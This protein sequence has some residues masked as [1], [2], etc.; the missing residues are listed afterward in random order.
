[1]PK[2]PEQFDFSKAEDQQ[3]LEKLPKKEREKFIESQA[4]E[5]Y[6]INDLVSSG[7][8]GNFERADEILSEYKKSPDFSFEELSGSLEKVKD[9]KEKIQTE[10]QKIKE[11]QENLKRLE[12]SKDNLESNRELLIRIAKQQG[13]ETEE[14]EKFDNKR[15][16]KRVAGNIAIEKAEEFIGGEQY[17]K[18]KE[19]RASLKRENLLVENGIEALRKQKDRGPK[20]EKEWGN[21]QKKQEQI[22]ERRD[23]ISSELKTLINKK[24]IGDDNLRLVAAEALGLTYDRESILYESPHGVREFKDS[25]KAMG[26]DMFT[27]DGR[28]S[29]GDTYIGYKDRVWEKAR[30]HVIKEYGSIQGDEKTTQETLT[31]LQEQEKLLK[32]KLTGTEENKKDL[33]VKFNG[34][35]KL[36]KRGNPIKNIEDLMP[37]VIKFVG[38]ENPAFVKVKPRDG[39]VVMLNNESHYYGSGG[40]ESGVTASIIRNEPSNKD[41]KYYIWRDPYDQRKDDRR[42]Y[43][44]RVKILKVEKDSVK[45]KLINSSKNF[46]MALTLNVKEI[47]KP[48]VKEVLAEEEQKI[49]KR[50]YDKIR[51]KLVEDSFLSNAIMPDYINYESFEGALPS[52]T[53]TE[54][55]VPYKRPR[56]VEEFVDETQGVAAVIIKS[57]IDHAAGRGKQFKWEGYIVDKNGNSRSVWSDNAYEVEMR[58]GKRIE[59]KAVDL[60]KLAE[61]KE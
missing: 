33:E 47:E 42:F 8:A 17:N 29:D 14:I 20:W 44:D 40:C 39:V 21:L 6:A 54:R 53:S 15:L 10:F 49:W 12:Q 5:G 3:K 22:S 16:T 28:Y 2:S 61:K 58:Q 36:I 32:E 38:K 51:E 24:S 18:I 13:L 27:A 50:N 30:E 48:K 43:F 46:E 52:G 23:E 37:W 31:D 7:V 59:M 25:T 11:Y 1:M 56:V 34:Y 57:Q 55:M 41:S 45:I 9:L 60:L 35:S 4:E 26:I 19:E